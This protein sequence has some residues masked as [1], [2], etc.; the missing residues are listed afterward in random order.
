MPPEFIFQRVDGFWGDDACYFGNQ[1]SL[2]K[3]HFVRSI[4]GGF[5]CHPCQR[6][7]WQGMVIWVLHLVINC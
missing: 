7:W 3:E 6:L 2:G 5:I 1:V 4:F